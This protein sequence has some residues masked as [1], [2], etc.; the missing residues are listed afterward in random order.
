[1][2]FLLSSHLFKS[3]RYK[4]VKGDINVI[5]KPSSFN[6]HRNSETLHCLAKV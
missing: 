4:I 5:W 3:V 6:K 2:I 1:M